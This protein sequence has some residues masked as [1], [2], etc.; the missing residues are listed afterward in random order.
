MSTARSVL[1]VRLPVWKIWP[2][3]LIYLAD[4]LHKERADLRQKPP[5]FARGPRAC[6]A[7]Q[8]VAAGSGDAQTL[9][10]QVDD[11][12][13]ERRSAP[14]LLPAQRVGDVPGQIANGQMKCIH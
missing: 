4:F 12:L 1:Y 10:Q 7:R 3:G 5:L 2:G 14:A 6:Q 13:V 9:P 11:G 8:T